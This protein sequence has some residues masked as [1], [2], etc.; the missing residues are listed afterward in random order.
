[1]DGRS[2]WLTVRRPSAAFIISCLALMAA[3]GGSA[4]AAKLITG[5]QIKDRSITGRDLKSNTITGRVAANL[6]GRD[7][8]SDSLDGTDISENQLGTV[9]R[10]RSASQADVADRATSAATADALAGARVARVHFAGAAGSEDT[11]LDLGGL[12][13]LAACNASGVMTV[14]ASTATGPGWIRVAGSQQAGNNSAAAVLLED[15]DFRPGDEF[16]VLPATADNVGGDVIYVAA[17]G[18]TVTVTFLAEQGVA[19]ARGYACLF[20]GTAVQAAA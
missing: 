8:L 12:R 15:D 17:D 10:A 11:V 20:A 6:S 5:K 4:V 2:L 1:M 7:I 3:L 16:S 13:L 9:P 18:S 14:T 19:A